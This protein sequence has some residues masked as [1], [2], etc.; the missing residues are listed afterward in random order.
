MFCVLYVIDLAKETCLLPRGE[1]EPAPPLENSYGFVCECFY[2]A[3][4]SLNLGFH[5]VSEKFL[6]RN[7]DLHRVQSLFQEIASQGG[8][9]SDAGQRIKDQMEKGTNSLKV[10]A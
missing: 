6:K 7:Q 8:D 4:V 5:V 3:H 1:N 2:L 9:T 10:D